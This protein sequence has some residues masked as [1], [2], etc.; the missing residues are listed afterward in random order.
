MKNKKSQ[1]WVETAIYTLIGL[2]IIA[3]LLA[4]A[5]PQIEKI[6]DKG[7]INQAMDAMNIIDGKLSD[8]EQSIG[9]VGIASV[10]IG[11]GKLK[12]NSPNDSL[13]YSLENTRLEFSQ[14]GEDVRNGNL[15]VRTE[16]H[17]S[18][19]NI[20]LIRYYNGIN[21]TYD[22]AEIE[23]ALQPG[24]VPYRIR[25]ENRGKDNVNEKIIIDFSTL[26]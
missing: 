13:E 6:K 4:I 10:K 19:F 23:K 11:E 1:I 15:I 22:R 24:A 9:G 8:V 21:I 17:G 2:T 12:I 20:Y 16:K 3:I 18:R 14:V 25:I 26:E 7:T 5:N